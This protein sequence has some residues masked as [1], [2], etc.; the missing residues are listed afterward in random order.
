[1]NLNPYQSPTIAGQSPAEVPL[2]FRRRYWFE[3][4]IV[5]DALLLLIVAVADRSVR[6]V[7]AW[8]YLFVVGC[9]LSAPA[10]ALCGIVRSILLLN[11]KSAWRSISAASFAIMV[12]LAHYTATWIDPWMETVSTRFVVEFVGQNWPKGAPFP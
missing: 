9:W 11:M 8:Y 12:M 4:L 1:M 2:S 7:P 6:E 5:G 10:L 3:M